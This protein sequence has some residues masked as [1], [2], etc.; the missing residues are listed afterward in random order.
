MHFH[1]D[2]EENK[3]VL[4]WAIMFVMILL[5]MLFVMDTFVKFYLQVT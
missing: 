5:A 1:E 3:Y 4:F 2:P